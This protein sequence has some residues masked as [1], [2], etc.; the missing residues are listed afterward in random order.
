MP[1][2]SFPNV[3]LH[4]AHTYLISPYEINLLSAAADL[5]LPSLC[6]CLEVIYIYTPYITVYRGKATLQ[7]YKNQISSFVIY[8]ATSAYTIVDLLGNT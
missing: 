7:I 3:I 6:I 2:R 8:K 5:F 1:L 4:T